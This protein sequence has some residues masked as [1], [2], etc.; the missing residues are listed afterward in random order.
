MN[1]TIEVFTAECP[2]C[3]EALRQITEAA[4]PSC[5]VTSV[6]TLSAEGLAR[7]REL[8]VPPTPAGQAYVCG[9]IG[10]PKETRL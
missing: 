1:R 9:V 4:C 5:E 7:A 8:G 2:I 3:E 10:R 6:S